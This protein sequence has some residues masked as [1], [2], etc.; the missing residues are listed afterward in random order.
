MK[1]WSSETPLKVYCYIEVAIDAGSISKGAYSQLTGPQGLY[2]RSLK[3]EALV[4]QVW[5]I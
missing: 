1:N 4:E 5:T 2:K 3:R